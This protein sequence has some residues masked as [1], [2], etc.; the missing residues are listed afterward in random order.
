M[1]ETP[2]P[3]GTISRSHSSL[4]RQL[5]KLAKFAETEEFLE[6]TLDG[7]K[8]RR[9]RFLD[10]WNQLNKSNQ[11][12]LDGVDNDEGVE[13]LER[14]MDTAENNYFIAIE[15]MDKRFNELSPQPEQAVNANETAQ[16]I[17]EERPIN[18][19]VKLPYQQHNMKNT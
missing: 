3:T 18:V 16:T 17:G 13:E 12:Q 6:L 2:R 19:N 1:N 10:I 15:I 5:E 7:V 9:E 14:R 8:I 11:T 4:L